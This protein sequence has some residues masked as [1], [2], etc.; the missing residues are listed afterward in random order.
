MLFK[1]NPNNNIIFEELHIRHLNLLI[2]LKN[3][4]GNNWFYK[5]A[6]ISTFED[7]KI[8]LVNLEKNKN[9]CIIA[10]QNNKLIGY[11]YTYPLNEKKT[12][13]KINVPKIIYENNSLSNRD[14]IKKLIKNSIILTDLRTSSWI[15]YS[16]IHN[17]ELISCSRELGFQP[18][19]EI[20]LWSNKNNIN[21][22]KNKKFT[23][24]KF[25][26]INKNN[27]K[28]VL[29]FVRSNES[30]LIRNILDLEIEDIY[31]MIDKNCGV[32]TSCEEINF[33]ILRDMG[34][35]NDNVYLLLGGLCWDERI[36]SA[37]RNK[38]KDILNN[39]NNIYFKTYSSNE[40]LNAFL[41]ES[42]LTTTSQEIILV[43]NTLIKREVKSINQINKSIE[44]IIGKINPQG[45]AY[46][47]PSPIKLK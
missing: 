36:N 23:T 21:D 10:I 31:R 12:C 43:R 26:K 29:N 3:H 6:L 24:K 38:I 17:N 5:M 47:S 41:V 40:T 19:Q 2:D 18:L 25:S 32:Y 9:K 37:L 1:K 14:L 8:F 22:F 45:N 4:K 33:C 13:L 44:N 42:N 28:K 39:D 16:D 35:E 20:T 46:P 30:I 11:V 27:I 34:Y 7:L 15:I